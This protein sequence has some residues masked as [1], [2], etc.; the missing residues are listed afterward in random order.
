MVIII[1]LLG[2]STNMVYAKTIP[3]VGLN[4][5]VSQLTV[6][7]PLTPHQVDALPENSIQNTGTMTETISF[8]NTDHITVYPSTIT[9]APRASAF[10]VA[11]IHASAEVGSHMALL[12]I[13]AQGQHIPDSLR[14]VEKVHY[15]TKPIPLYRLWL[16]WLGDHGLLLSEVMVGL[17]LLGSLTTNII[18][19]ARR[20]KTR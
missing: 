19:Y 20:N 2:V 18:Q 14:F 3:S 5:A 7:Q 11:E 9:L 17:I 16:L 12:Y 15:T 10:F 4:L 6:L 13:S 8:A 1:L